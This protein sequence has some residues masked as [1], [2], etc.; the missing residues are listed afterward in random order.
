MVIYTNV[1]RVSSNV[2]PWPFGFAFYIRKNWIILWHQPWRPQCWSDEANINWIGLSI[3][4]RGKLCITSC[5][6]LIIVSFSI[7]YLSGPGMQNHRSLWGSPFALR[8]W[9]QYHI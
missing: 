2:D 6:S 3:H 4:W 7:M 5:S 8:Q 1:S 9:S